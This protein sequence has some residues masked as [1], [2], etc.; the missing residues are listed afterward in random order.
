[1]KSL[2]AIAITAALLLSGCARNYNSSSR[3]YSNTH[4]RSTYYHSRTSSSQRHQHHS[5]G[6]EHHEHHRDHDHGR[7]HHH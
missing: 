4:T 5:G 6:R 7:E 3:P 2:L 1:M